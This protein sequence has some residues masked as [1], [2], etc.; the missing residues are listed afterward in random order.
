MDGIRSRVS[1]SGWSSLLSGR[2]RSVSFE[3]LALRNAYSLALIMT[4]SKV[5]LFSQLRASSHPHAF[6]RFMTSSGS[7]CPELLW[8]CWPKSMCSSTRSSRNSS[9][10]S[11]V[12]RS[13][14]AS[15]RSFALL[16]ATSRSLEWW[17]R[18]SKS[19]NCASPVPSPHASWPGAATR[20]SRELPAAFGRPRP[21]RHTTASAKPSKI[22]CTSCH[23]SAD[24]FMPSASRQALTLLTSYRPLSSRP[25]V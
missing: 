10:C 13:S 15:R 19:S 2:Y 6:S 16:A 23:S 20:L 22:L 12:R 17:T 5:S 25:F 18:A 8:P 14:S 21:E 11:S 1:C 3:V 9:N 7:S 4:D 24:T